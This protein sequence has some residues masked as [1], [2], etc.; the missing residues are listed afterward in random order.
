MINGQAIINARRLSSA[1]STASVACD[2]MR[3]W[4][5]GT[6]KG[7]WVSMGVYSD[8][9]YGIQPSLIYSF[10]ITCKKGEWSIVQGLKIDEFS[11]EKM[12]AVERELIEKIIMAYSAMKRWLNQ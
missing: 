4:I 1:F 8:G 5:L 9:S 6:P 11:R 7:T 10:P 3:D 2:H 12:H